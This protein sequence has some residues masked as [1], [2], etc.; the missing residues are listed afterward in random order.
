[1][2]EFLLKTS[3]RTLF[4]LEVDSRA[5]MINSFDVAGNV[6]MPWLHR[7]LN[8]WEMDEVFRLLRLLEGIS[9]DLNLAD[10]LEWSIT[11]HGRFTCKSLYLEMV[12]CNNRDFPF[13]GI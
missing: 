3:F 10:G 8:D 2:G 13:K 6:W 1:M 12:E 7:D 5:L 11:K 4:S 9:P